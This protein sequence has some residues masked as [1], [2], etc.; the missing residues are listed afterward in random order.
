MD[1]SVSF[2]SIR[3]LHEIIIVLHAIL[4]QLLAMR[5]VLRQLF[6]EVLQQFLLLL[7]DTFQLLVLLEEGHHHA[8]VLLG[9]LHLEALRHWH[10]LAVLHHGRLHGGTLLNGA[11]Y[12]GGWLTSL[13]GHERAGLRRKGLL[14]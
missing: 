13:G 14:N 2:Q 5:L 9:L 8:L 7:H 3:R 10:G 6:A 1:I 12:L 4:L 11:H